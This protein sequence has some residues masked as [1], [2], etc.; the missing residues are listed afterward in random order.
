[1][2]EREVLVAPLTR[3]DLGRNHRAEAVA[4]AVAALRERL[5]ILVHGRPS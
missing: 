5:A 4:V 3:L 1:M 2:V